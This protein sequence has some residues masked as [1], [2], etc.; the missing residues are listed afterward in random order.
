MSEIKATVIGDVGERF[1]AVYM[2]R[3]GYTIVES[4]YRAKFGEIDIIA[5]KDEY[6]VFCEVKSR[7]STAFGN[8][9]EFVD[10]RKQKKIIKTAYK[11]IAENKIEAAVRFDVCEVF[12]RVNRA[13]EIVLEDINYIE[14]AFEA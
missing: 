2:R 3:N 5:K 10:F 6:I 13:G 14:G 7:R 9:S 12:H 8:P 1:A 4:N 11:Y